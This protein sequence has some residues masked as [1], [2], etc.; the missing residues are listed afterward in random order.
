MST[1]TTTTASVANG[2]VNGVLTVNGAG[3]TAAGGDADPGAL[4]T[5]INK[6][7]PLPTVDG[8]TH[9]VCD[10]LPEERQALES[11]WR[12]LP[13][14]FK[15]DNRELI[16]RAYLLASNAH[17][18]V[19]RESGEPYIT[20]PIAVAQLLTELRIHHAESGHRRRGWRW[21]RS[22]CAVG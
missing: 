18:G 19:A 10:P 6:L 2:Y 14:G 15:Q 5:L 3:V 16:L 17:H 4:W 11:L 9:L 1:A 22:D 7:R 13:E 12:N 21:G 8:S 20:H